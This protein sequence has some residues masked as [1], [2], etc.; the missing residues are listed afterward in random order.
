MT[1]LAIREQ[2]VELVESFKFLGTTITNTLKW[3]INAETIAKKAQQRMFFLRQ[4]QKFRINKTILTQFYRAV[5]ESVL[6]FSITV[7][8][9]S[10]SIHNQ[11][12]LEG[13]V[14]TA[15]KITG[16]K[17]PLI[18][19]IYTTRTLCKAT[20]IISDC[21]HPANHLF[22]SLPSGKRFRSIKT[23]T[24]RFSKFLPKSSSN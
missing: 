4:L 9:G 20:I 18:E 1:P 22:E 5:T 17:L 11:N 10:A 23:R 3:D 13:I 6:T 24:T 14:K 15:S 19:S 21:T 7:W 12:M 16:S 8:F 2:Q